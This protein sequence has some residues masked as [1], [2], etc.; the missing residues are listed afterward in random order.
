[1]YHGYIIV[2]QGGFHLYVR[3]DLKEVQFSKTTGVHSLLVIPNSYKWDLMTVGTAVQVFADLVQ[4]IVHN[5][6]KGL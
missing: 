4:Q 2:G 6:N 1:M 3:V 5:H